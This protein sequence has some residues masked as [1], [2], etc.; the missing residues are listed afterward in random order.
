MEEG[1]YFGREANKIGGQPGASVQIELLIRV[2][3]PFI[4]RQPSGDNSSVEK[5]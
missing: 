5:L 2:C 1:H 4:N 3:T